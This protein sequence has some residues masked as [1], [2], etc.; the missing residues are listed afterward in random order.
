MAEIEYVQELLSYVPTMLAKR[1]VTDPA[2]LE[3]PVAERFQAVVMLVDITG[4]TALTERWAMP[5]LD[6]AEAISELLNNYFSQL[7]EIIHVYGGDVVKFAGDALLAVWKDATPLDLTLLASSCA[8]NI[9]QKLQ[10]YSPAEGVFLTMRIGLGQGELV[11]AHVGGMRGRWEFVVTGVPVTQA[12]LAE[13]RAAPG[14]VVVSNNTLER[15]M[16]S[17]LTEPLGE[18]ALKGLQQKMPVFAIL[19]S[20]AAPAGPSSAP[21]T[22]SATRV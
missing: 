16:G 11:A 5:G 18:F 19:G 12:S 14:Q 7:I 13:I 17:F 6:G 21:H 1:L 20:A 22:L 10:N 9:Q 15:I 3:A 4:F 2:P 8:L